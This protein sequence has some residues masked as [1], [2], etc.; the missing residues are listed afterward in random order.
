MRK[1]NVWGS[2]ESGRVGAGRVGSGRVGHEA[3]TAKGQVDVCIFNNN[4]TTVYFRS[5]FV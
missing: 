1:P 4:D 2:R 3:R 5:L